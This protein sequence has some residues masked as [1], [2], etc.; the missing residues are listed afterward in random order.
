MIGAWS[1]KRGMTSSSSSENHDANSLGPK[2]INSGCLAGRVYEMKQLLTETLRVMTATH[3]DDQL[4][5]MDYL[6]RNPHLITV[7]DTN[8]L[9]L[10][11]YKFLASDVS[12]NTTTGKLIIHQKESTVGLLHF[13]SGMV[14]DLSNM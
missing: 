7:D 10:C 6:F 11:L 4:A 14:N 3:R 9:F 13:N 12:I 2:F 5:V 1:Y 8:Q